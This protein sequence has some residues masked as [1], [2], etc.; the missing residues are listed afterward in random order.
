[1]AFVVRPQSHVDEPLSSAYAW[2]RPTRRS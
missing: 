1:M 2:F